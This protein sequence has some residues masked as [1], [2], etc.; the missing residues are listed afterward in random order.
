MMPATPA[1]PENEWPVLREE[2]LLHKGPAMADGSPSW[3]IEDPGRGS[4]FRVGWAEAEMLGAWHLGSAS[5]I[6]KAVSGKTT[7]HLTAEDIKQ[8]AQ[9]LLQQQLVRVQGE[10]GVSSL[11][12]RARQGHATWYQQLLHHYLF[13]RIPL[14][15]PEAFLNKT[16]PF[17]RAW[18][19]CRG[20]MLVT[21]LVGV[22]GIFLVMR[23]WDMFLHT[24]PYFFTFEGAAFAGATLVLAKIAHEFG[25]AYACKYFGCRVST[26]GVAFMVL[27]PVLYTDTS[28][29]WRLQSRRQRMCIG[30]AG[31]LSETMLAA[32]ATFLWS[33]LPDG[34][35]RS[36]V[37]VLATTTWILTLAVNLN[38]F[39]RFDGYFL[40]SDALSVPNLQA[41]SFALAKW[42]MRKWLFGWEDAAPEIMEP[43]RERVL[44][45][46]A[47]SVWVYRFFLF[48]G[49]ALLVYHVAF[50]VLGILLFLVEI[51]AF[52]LRPVVH[53]CREWMRRRKQMKW[54][55]HTRIM[56]AGGATML[57]LALL[58]WRTSVHA[59]AL[60]RAEQL[61]QVYAPSGVQ[62]LQTDMRQ[63]QVVQQGETLMVLDVPTLRHELESVERRQALLQWQSAFHVMNKE[64]RAQVLV[65]QNELSAVSERHDVLVRQQGQMTVRA[66]FT[67][68]VADIASDLHAG[69]WLESGEWIATL[70][71]PGK[72]L[73]EAYVTESDLDRLATGQKAWFYPADTQ[74]AARQAQVVNVAH[75]TTNDLV[76]VPELA[77]VHGGGIA[78]VRNGQKLQPEQ[79]VYR[80]VLA[81]PPSSDGEVVRSMT[82][83]VVIHGQGRS[84]LMQV[85]RQSMAVLIRELSF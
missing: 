66:P 24:F 8:F 79:A 22:T 70:V 67:G 71:V 29:A 64:T 30:A 57:L 56:V 43:W 16:L 38:P 61:M 49:I 51:G 59:P 78:A 63:G 69:E 35:L 12:H 2:L 65:A 23:Q 55:R 44:T 73:V 46:Y 3:T 72:D 20:F 83:R 9:F 77:S 15:R 53:E 82:G 5:A 32:W 58:P 42:R 33:F 39:M 50:K 48:L 25:H 11:V 62:L 54:N 19:L 85:W 31:M 1:G 27:W 45:L 75:A 4:F 18:I 28:G 52:I 14:W 68:V 60:L 17:M 6:I 7:L 84:W 34:I 21:A 76:M 26:M 74:A 13:F 47:W 80:V 10:K 41:R 37:F 40:L 81:L 36:A